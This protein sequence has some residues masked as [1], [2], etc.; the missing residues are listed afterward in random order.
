MEMQIILQSF[1]LVSKIAQFKSYAVGLSAEGLTFNLCL[2]LNHFMVLENIE[3]E[4]SH[5]RNVCIME[6]VLEQIL[7]W[8]S[9]AI[10][11]LLISSERSR[12]CQMFSFVFIIVFVSIIR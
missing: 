10:L 12:V 11:N 6:S 8:S 5:S 7:Q 4:T 2:S 1:V 9:V 3:I